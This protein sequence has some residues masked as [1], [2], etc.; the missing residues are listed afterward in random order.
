MS[1][2]QTFIITETRGCCS[3]KILCQGF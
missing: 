2:T 3:R 1:V